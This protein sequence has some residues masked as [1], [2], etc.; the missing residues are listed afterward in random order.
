V[1]RDGL[2]V[3]IFPEG[4]RGAGDLERFHRGAAYFALVTG[5]TVVPV[6]IFGS[7]EP[8]AGSNSLPRRGTTIDIVYGEPYQVDPV[9]W[10]RTKEQVAQSSLLLR[11]HMLIQLDQARA[12]TG[13]DLPGPLPVADAD[14]DP[15]TG[16]TEEGAP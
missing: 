13:R 4:S 2:T 14:P 12:D 5:A 8:G 9:P 1:L 16:V 7:R 15:A 10:P 6:S 3:G 11:K